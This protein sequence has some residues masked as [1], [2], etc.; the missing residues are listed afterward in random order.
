MFGCD[1]YA[2]LGKRKRPSLTYELLVTS[3][4]TLFS[5]LMSCTASDPPL[6]RAQSNAT[7]S[8]KRRAR[9]CQKYHTAMKGHKTVRKATNA[10][11]IASV[12]PMFVPSPCLAPVQPWLVCAPV[13]ICKSL[14]SKDSF[15]FTIHSSLPFLGSNGLCF[16][17]FLEMYD[18]PNLL[19]SCKNI[20]GIAQGAAG[21]LGRLKV[22]LTVDL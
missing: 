9:R 4:S 8:L 20:I 13:P 15:T 21:S 1:K 5:S 7:S 3:A 17:F 6:F 11:A 19:Y 14:V 2:K 10:E 16:F 12:R 22:D 18:I